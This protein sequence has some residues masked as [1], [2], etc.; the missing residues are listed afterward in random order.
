M[1]YLEREGGAIARVDA[2][3]TAFPH[4]S[5]RYGLHILPGWSKPS[6][7][8]GLMRWA[9]EFQDAMGPFANGGVYVNLL[10]E[11]ELGRVADAA[12]GRNYAR[13]AE[14]KAAWDPENVF[15]GNHNVEPG[16]TTEA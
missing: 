14:V 12:Y 4:R 16:R 3:A 9:R 8:E 7:D 10:G 13:L 6:D 1:A 2:G 5:A 11:D 15:R